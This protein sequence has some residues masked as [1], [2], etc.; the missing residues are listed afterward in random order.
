MDDA[1]LLLW[2]IE[3]LQAAVD[4]LDEGN[5]NSFGRRM[6]WKDGSYVGQMLRGARPITEKFV[7]KFETECGLKGWFDPA[8]QSE[9]D[10]LEYQVRTEMASRVVPEHVLQTILDLV[11][12]Y[13][14]RANSTTFAHQ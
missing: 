6:G 7:R 2:R 14:K 4:R 13:P 10:S 12:G 11:K 8:E 1:E 3:R 5:L 9:S